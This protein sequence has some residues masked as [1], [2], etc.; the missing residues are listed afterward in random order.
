MGIPEMANRLRAARI[1]HLVVD[2]CCTPFWLL[3]LK[4]TPNGPCEYAIT[5]AF[6]KWPGM[7]DCKLIYGDLDADALAALV[8]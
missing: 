3:L 1:H 7:T 5:A 4:K 2:K 6:E 8:G